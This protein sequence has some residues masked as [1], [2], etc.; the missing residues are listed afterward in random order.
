MEKQTRLLRS[1]LALALLV[2]VALLLYVL[3]AGFMVGEGRVMADIATNLLS[4]RGYELSREMLYPSDL[5]PREFREM[6]D[7][8]F[9]FYRKV[10]GFYGVLRPGRETAFLVPGYILFMAGVFRVA[11]PG[12]L[13]A[14]RVVQLLVVGM[15]SVMA[16]ISI[17]RRFL[18]GKPLLAAA[19]FMAVDPFE[20]YFEAVPATQAL[21]TLS[22]LASLLASMRVLDF[23]RPGR[24]ALA[25]AAWGAAFLIRP[26][27]LSG[28]AVFLAVLVLSRRG[29]AR[30][31][32]SALI[33][34]AAAAALVFPW[35]L[36][37]RAATGEWRVLPTQGGV[38]MWEFNGRIFSSSFVGELDGMT[39]LYDPLR[40]AMQ[41][42]ISRLDLAEFP[43]FSDESEAFR[44]SVLTSRTL[45]F[46]AANPELLARL[47]LL[48]FAD[49]VKP[50]SYNQMYPLYAA[51][52]ILTWG[53][54]LLFAGGGAILLLRRRSPTA[55]LLVIFTLL[56]AAGH[57]ATV[58]G[59]PI[60]VAIDFPVAVLA[61]AGLAE[62]AGRIGSVRCRRAIPA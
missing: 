18:T 51:A 28:A 13:A 5:A 50:F 46:L 41:G 52:G 45:Q 21:F 33:A 34:L 36:R 59:I 48:R 43:S 40:T 35:A 38:N 39:T 10:D 54:A 29:F 20:L 23:P 42:R 24:A 1:V 58:S 57:V 62:V 12:N 17:A 6:H 8:A 44:D 11:G 49:F 60:R 15:L 19:L 61:G 2:R 22:I 56:Y 14:V 32:G 16:G 26:V 7:A 4:G 30:R 37:N 9:D 25:G 53:L 55:A 3:R 47:V 27:A 31:L